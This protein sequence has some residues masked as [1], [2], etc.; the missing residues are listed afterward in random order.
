MENIEVAVM[1]GSA[2][3]TGLIAYYWRKEANY[4]KQ[5]KDAPRLNIDR[6]L[7]TIV[8]EAPENT[9]PYAVIEGSVEAI[10]KPLQSEHTPGILGVLQ[11][12][13][14]R[15]HK[16]Y[17]SGSTRLWHDTT[18][19]IRNINR[20]VPFVIKDNNAGVKVDDPLSATGLEIPIIHDSFEPSPTSL[21]E[22]IVSWASGEK[23]KGFQTMERM[24]S[25]GTVLTGIGM[26]STS[27]GSLV[28]GP[29]T[30]T[31]RPYILS[32]IGFS[33][34][35]RDFQS[36]INHLKF[37]LYISGSITALLVA[38]W[39]Y[40][41]YKKYAERRNHEMQVERVLQDRAE[42]GAEGTD[43][44]P[45]VSEDNACTICLSNRRD[46]VLLDCGHICTCARCARLLQPPQC[47]ICRQRIKRVVPLYH[48]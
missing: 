41:Q 15:E 33:G 37:F 40:K 9:I 5:I 6:N 38:L 13:I 47:P 24:L 43:V 19:L 22:H 32:N 26:L 45:T 17:W 31:N 10:G 34:I 4:L 46:V 44:D 25:E 48:S 11:T 16:T 39:F 21:G 27:T 35:V 29:P 12:L 23:T 20:S 14:C 8:S 7:Q 42:E 3:I 18:R 28:L 36:K 30:G 2:A 1:A